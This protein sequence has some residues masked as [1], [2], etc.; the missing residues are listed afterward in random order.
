M[1]IIFLFTPCGI[2][3][4]RATVTVCDHQLFQF[5]LSF[6]VLIIFSFF[7]E[8]KHAEL[9]EVIGL[10]SS[11]DIHNDSFVKGAKTTSCTMS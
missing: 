2:A 10:Y 7:L 6:T 4:R 8:C 3:L 5:T 9:I 11:P 1:E